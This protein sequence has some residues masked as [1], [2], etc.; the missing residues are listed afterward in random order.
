MAAIADYDEAIRLDPHYA[1]AHYNRG[2]SRAALGDKPGAIAD[3]ERP[4]SLFME[5]A[6]A[7]RREEALRLAAA[8]QQ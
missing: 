8:L 6:D 1:H 5:P 4:A 7:R 2:L 3:Y